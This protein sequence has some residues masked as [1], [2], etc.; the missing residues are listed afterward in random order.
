MIEKISTI[1]YS[2][3]NEKI[4]YNDVRKYVL[5]NILLII[6]S[7]I[8]IIFTLINFFNK[9]S[10]ILLNVDLIGL[11]A[12]IYAFFDLR[13]NHTLKKASLIATINIFLLLFAVVYFGKAEN[14]TLIWTI[15]FPVF[16][17]FIHGCRKGIVISFI[18]Y[19]IVFSFA[20]FNIGVWLD[21]QWNIASFLRYVAANLA[22][23]F[24]T[25]F[26]ERS[27]ESA[28]K[29]L[30]KNR[31]IEQRYISALETASI[32]DPLTQLYNRRYLDLAFHEQFLKAKAHQSYFAFFILDLDNFKAFNDTYGHIAGDNALKK[33]ANVLKESMRRDADGAFRLG[34][35]EFAGILMAD[36][37]EKICRS[38][39]QIRKKIEALGIKH[40]KNPY[41]VLTISIGI[42]IIH[43]FKVED[44]DKMYKIADK[45]L[46]DAKHSGRNTL[47]GCDKIST[48]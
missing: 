2:G 48:L 36:S 9:P 11:L 12:N 43:D 7:F 20:F 5:L 26:F 23:L 24:I 27:F 37:K 16:A 42:A 39:E 19:L 22:M 6:S 34:G 8:I 28:H 17:I 40:E 41:S 4:P 46:Y 30:A 38:V 32:T 47:K 35:E 1:F 44:F 10:S 14:F 25:Y 15:F 31:D 3:V 33:V 29:E 21:G 18:F 13:F 45:A